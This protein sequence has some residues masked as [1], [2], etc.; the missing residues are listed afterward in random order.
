MQ[1]KLSPEKTH[2][3]KKQIEIYYKRNH[4]HFSKSNRNS[5]DSIYMSWFHFINKKRA[6]SC[7]SFDKRS[8]VLSTFDW[9]LVT[10]HN[11]TV[12]FSHLQRCLIICVLTCEEF[13]TRWQGLY[14]LNEVLWAFIRFLEE[15]MKNVP[16]R[17]L[18]LVL[19]S[20]HLRWCHNFCRNAFT[21]KW[22]TSLSTSGSSFS[23]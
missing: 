7:N 13:W 3:K 12:V 20:R 11:S 15:T 4:K 22:D 2:I 14:L 10:S 23:L 1:N 18:V 21:S 17:C 8:F 5:K 6:A 19:T 16:R 9:M